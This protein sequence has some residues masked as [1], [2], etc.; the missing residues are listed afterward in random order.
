MLEKTADNADNANVI[1]QAGD[2]RA[3]TTNT[4]HDQIDCHLGRGGFVERLD[5]LL[6]D[7]RIEFGDDSGRS[8]RARVVPLTFD[9]GDEPF[10][11]IERRYHEFFQARIT[12]EPGQ[13]V[14]NDC[15]LLG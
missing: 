5:D 3:Q 1:A 4:A 13:R 14:E 6:I 2:L 11:H 15:D 10:L 9:Q 8:P 12:G 7:Q